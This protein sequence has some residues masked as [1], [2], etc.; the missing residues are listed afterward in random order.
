MLKTRRIKKTIIIFLI[1]SLIYANCNTALFSIIS[2]ANDV[3]TTGIENSEENEEPKEELQIETTEFVKNKMS[4]QE[5][6]YQEELTINFSHDKALKEITVSEDKTLI[7]NDTQSETQETTE[8]EEK[9]LANVFYKSTKINKNELIN[10]I[11]ENGTLEI[12]YTV[13]ETTNNTEAQVQSNQNSLEEPDSYSMTILSNLNENGVLNPGVIIAE[14][15][16]V[17]IDNS[18]VADSE[19]NITIIYPNKVNFTSAKIS[20]DNKEVS[21][22]KIINTRTIEAIENVDNVK[23]LKITKRIYVK[24]S[25]DEVLLNLYKTT[26]KQIGYSR[27]T[28]SLGIDRD[29]FSTRVANKTYFTITM[30]TNSD[31]YDLYKNPQ[32]IIE[33]PDIVRDVTIDGTVLINNT[34]FTIA[35]TKIVD[36]STGNKGILVKLNGEQ[37]AMTSE[38]ENT[39][40]VVET[41]IETDKLI[42]TVE[43][44]FNLFYTNEAAKSYNVSGTATMGSETVKVQFVSDKDII[45]ETKATVGEKSATAN[46]T[47]VVTT[48]DART[49]KIE[50]TI[51]NNT[52]EK[53]DAVILGAVT[54]MSEIAEIQNVYY[55]E[56]ENATIDLTNTQNGWST[57]KTENAKKYL[58]VVNNFEQGQIIKY[59]YSVNMVDGIKE[60]YDHE[61]KMDIY[62]NNE[63]KKTSK[64]TIRQEAKRE[65]EVITDKIKANIEIDHSMKLKIMNGTK[66]K[67]NIENLTEE[68]MSNVTLDVKLPMVFK[69]IYS[70]EEFEGS[71]WDQK[72]NILHIPNITIEKK[73]IK[74]ILINIVPE[75]F[76]K[77]VETITATVLYEDKTIELSDS[78]ELIAP[79]T[80]K[81]TLTSNKEGVTLKP[82][83]EIIYTVNLKNESSE[84]ASVNVKFPSITQ[85]DITK[86]EYKNKTTGQTKYISG[87]SILGEITSIYLNGEDEAEIKLYCIAKELENDSTQVVYASIT[88]RQIVDTETNKLT[89]KISKKTQTI[90]DNPDKPDK[91]DQPDKPD[92]PDK[93][94]EPVVVK[95][96][97]TVKGTAWLDKNQDGRRDNDEIL[98]KDIQAVLIDSKT[99]EEVAKTVTDAKGQYEFTKVKDGSYIVEFRYN[100]DTFTVT[101]YKKQGVDEE[102]NSDVIRTTQ[103]GETVAKTEVVELSGEKV[104]I[105]D[106]GFVVNKKFDMWLN[107]GIT[108]VTVRNDSGTESYSFNSADLAKVEIKDKYVKGSI[109]L[110]EYEISITNVGELEGFTK[111]IADNMPEGMTFNSELNSAW[112]EGTDGKLYCNSMADKELAP[113]ETAIVKLIL[114]KEMKDDKVGTILNKANIEEVYNEYLINDTNKENDSSEASLIVSIKTGQAESYMWLVIV[115]IAIIGIGT[116]GVIKITN[117]DVNVV[118]ERRK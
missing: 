82:N 108:K 1:M 4:E 87:A 55:T 106:A 100:T 56:N 12:D 19:G 58:I 99:S 94:D 78:I 42:P 18:T 30:K 31:I 86:I 38:E 51:I 23:L 103:N 93:P 10:K 32:F 114:T 81:A 27:T 90:P 88:G 66:F 26:S 62:Q 80:I 54:N 101:D 118:E 83:E 64:V 35:E 111:K 79:A 117:K 96:N 25:D 46:N 7:T 53:I 17:K 2:Y 73:S 76:E 65:I 6:E 63:I 21:D 104:A 85:F 24:A 5:T 50:E 8:T 113:G 48:D 71:S 107:K 77:T 74:T 89:N 61:I 34:V 69:Q 40:I 72:T 91:P 84:F 36:L 112:Y 105:F 22:L 13:L 41:T 52:E 28:A 47:L 97:N 45:T 33:V 11:G 95:N 109:I 49:V 29:K 37:V 43:K 15:G 44:E 102:L 68:D 67:I 115:V 39:Q 16:N 14:N 60:D 9:S 20:T 3:K 116:F 98:L 92:K 59:S 75:D 110:V 57:T 70:V